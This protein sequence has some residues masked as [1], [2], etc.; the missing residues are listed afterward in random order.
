MKGGKARG[1]AAA[2]KEVKNTKT[3]TVTQWS[4]TQENFYFRVYC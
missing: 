2:K 1:I 3:E 4:A